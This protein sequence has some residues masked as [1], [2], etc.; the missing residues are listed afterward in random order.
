[1]TKKKSPQ[2]ARNL[3]AKTARRDHILNESFKLFT[4]SD[5]DSISMEL[6]A[7]KSG[8]AKGTLYLYFQSKEEVFLSCTQKSF[9]EWSAQFCQKLDQQ[10]GLFSPSQLAGLFTDTLQANPDL[11][12]LLS[13]LHLVL[14]KN[15]S[16]EAAKNFKLFL[17]SQLH[18]VAQN[19]A[20]KTPFLRSPE[21]TISF[22]LKAYGLWVGLH[23]LCTPHPK[24]QRILSD[25]ELSI[26]LLNFNEQLNDALT[27]LLLGFEKLENKNTYHLFGNY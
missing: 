3:E 6:L 4:D 22:L 16:N 17:K 11:S 8:L 2:R 26:F 9:A 19:L 15:I 5:F 12:R 25:P 24:I 23:Q 10:T 20:G 27:L 7:S 14:E 21:V 1:M 13:H 18:Q